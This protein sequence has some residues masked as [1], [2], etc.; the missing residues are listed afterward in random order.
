MYSEASD[1]KAV[2]QAKEEAK[3][4]LTGEDLEKC[5]Q[6]LDNWLKWEKRRRELYKR[7]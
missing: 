5:L 2:E 7:G 4:N 3:K 6:A 1:I